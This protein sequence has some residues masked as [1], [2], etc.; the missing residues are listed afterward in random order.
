MRLKG[1]FGRK[2]KGLSDAAIADVLDKI[3]Q[4]KSAMSAQKEG[5][6][7]KI[8]AVK[9]LVASGGEKSTEEPKPGQ[10]RCACLCILYHDERE[11]VF[12][13]TASRAPRAI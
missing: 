1:R 6:R 7:G 2:P 10:P 12:A 9:S 5:L 4:Q 8:L 11:F 13:T 3:E